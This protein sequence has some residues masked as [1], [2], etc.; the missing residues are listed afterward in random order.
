MSVVSPE[1]ES[2]R[3]VINQPIS[4]DAFIQLLQ[5]TSLGARRPLA[6]RATM[7]GMIE[8]GNLLVTAWLGEQLIGIAR[9]VTDYHFACYLSDLAV[10]EAYQCRGIGKALIQHT[11]RQLGP[12]CGLLLLAAPAARDYYQHIGFSYVDRCW[13]LTADQPF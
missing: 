5:K 12:R 11:R 8:Q 13:Q 7:Q 2:I 1:A 9:S 6:D 10:D 3:Y 4:V